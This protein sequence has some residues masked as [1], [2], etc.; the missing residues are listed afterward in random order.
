MKVNGTRLC[1]TLI[2]P[3]YMTSKN[4]VLFG[5]MSNG[6]WPDVDPFVV[7]EVLT[8]PAEELVKPLV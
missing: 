3:T 6:C 5:D 4:C 8:V 2:L 7:V 1:D